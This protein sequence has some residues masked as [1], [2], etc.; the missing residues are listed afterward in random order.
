MYFLQVQQKC[1]LH[2]ID[3]RL[4]TLKSSGI[5]L[6]GLRWLP[7]CMAATDINNSTSPPQ[8]HPHTCGMA[9]GI[10]TD[11]PAVPDTHQLYN[12]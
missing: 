12:R 10:V 5:G 8:A 4:R 2:R 3:A 9:P 6:T 1:T 11:H 7:P